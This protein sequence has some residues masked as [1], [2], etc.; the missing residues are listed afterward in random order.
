MSEANEWFF[1]VKNLKLRETNKWF[2]LFLR[3]KNHNWAKQT[4]FV[5][6]WLKSQNWAKRTSETYLTD[7]ILFM[8]ILRIEIPS[9]FGF[10]SRSNFKLDFLF[11]LWLLPEKK[12][13]E[14][15]KLLCLKVSFYSHSHDDNRLLEKRDRGWHNHHLHWLSHDECFCTPPELSSGTHLAEYFSRIRNMQFTTPLPD[16]KRQKAHQLMT[17]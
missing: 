2:L 12:R 8:I 5:I 10:M 13:V 4:S 6:F 3:K 16:N 1:C 17:F 15:W 7:F 11:W 9:D 14:N